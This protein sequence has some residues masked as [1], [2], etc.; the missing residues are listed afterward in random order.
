MNDEYQNVIKWQQA[1][2]FL[3]YTALSFLFI[4][5]VVLDKMPK[6]AAQT[7]VW[8]F[9]TALMLM[10]TAGFFVS[11]KALKKHIDYNNKEM[12]RIKNG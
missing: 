11:Q 2:D 5:L 6:H 7:A 12:E 1:A 3:Q 8:Y 4:S 9:A 10:T